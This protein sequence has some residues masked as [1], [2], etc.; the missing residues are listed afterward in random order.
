MLAHSEF[1]EVLRLF[2]NDLLG[3]VLVLA[4]IGTFVTLIVSVIS[5]SRTWNNLAQIRMNQSL[6]KDLLNQGY[7]VEDI[8]RLV[9]GGGQRWGS[10]F[11]QLV[12]SARSRFS[13]ARNRYEY[14]NQPV[15]PVKQTA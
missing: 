1:V 4:T 2:D 5:I 9:Y 8:E 3:V 10:R 15:P 14:A 6:V 7:S 11:K 12:Q 13:R